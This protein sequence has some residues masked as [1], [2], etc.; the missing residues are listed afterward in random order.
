MPC[1]N[2]PEATEEVVHTP[3]HGVVHTPGGRVVH[4][5]R[6]WPVQ[7]NP[8]ADTQAPRAKE[9]QQQASDAK[10]H[11]VVDEARDA[12]ISLIKRVEADIAWLSREQAIIGE[13]RE[14]IKRAAREQ[15]RD[16]L[17]DA[18]ADFLRLRVPELV[19]SGSV[20]QD[21]ASK[22]LEEFDRDRLPIAARGISKLIEERAGMT[23]ELEF[24]DRTADL[25]QQIERF[26]R[27]NMDAESKRYLE[28]QIETVT[29]RREAV[30]EGFN[31]MPIA[32]VAGLPM[33]FVHPIV[34]AA[35]LLGGLLMQSAGGNTTSSSGSMQLSSGF[36]RA[37]RECAASLAGDVASGQAGAAIEAYVDEVALR[38]ADARARQRTG[39]PNVTTVA[40][41]LSRL[42]ELLSELD[43][44]SG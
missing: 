27:D 42:R 18:L 13:S 6:L 15:L 24:S 28:E 37:V 38:A 34:G 31:V 41:T 7:S 20:S 21:I 25:Q 3:A 43:V 40:G 10:G 2:D 36:E 4:M 32:A 39:A 11:D 5:G 9:T 16:S 35:I 17:A 33:L 12:L 14:T 30:R 22:V 26:A 1:S 23:W 29:E 44:A 19:S 8:A